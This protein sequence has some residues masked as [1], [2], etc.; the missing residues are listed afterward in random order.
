[1]SRDIQCIEF[2]KEFPTI[3]LKMQKENEREYEYSMLVLY[4]LET[5]HGFMV[6]RIGKTTSKGTKVNYIPFK[7]KEDVRKYSELLESKVKAFNEKY[8]TDLKLV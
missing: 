7:S 8:G 5:E 1:M 2:Q 4:T 3:N 6:K